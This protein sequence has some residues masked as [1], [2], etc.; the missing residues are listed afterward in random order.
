MKK[1]KRQAFAQARHFLKTQARPLERALFE[2]H[3]E[4]ASPQGVIAELAYFQN[5]DGGFG[6]ALEPDM[7]TPTSSAL[8]TGMG[9]RVLAD[10]ITPQDLAA[11]DTPL[12]FESAVKFLLDTFD[13]QTKVWRVVLPDANAYPHAG[14][15]HDADGSLARTF[16]DFV[17]IPRA[18]L[19]G[20]LHRADLCPHSASL[21]S[22]PWLEDLTEAT[23]V[24][25]RAMEEKA[26]GGGGDT[27]RYALDLVE[28]AGVPQSYKDRLIP[29][30]R[31]IATVVVSRDPAE[32]DSYCAPPLKIAPTPDA[33]VADILAESLQDHLDYQIAH[34]TSE[35]TWEPT[36]TWGEA[37]PEV[38]EQA[39][40]E[41]RGVLT[42]DTLVSLDA[43]GR[44]DRG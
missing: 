7:R 18:Q 27:L 32:W 40:R 5:Q 23:V 34:Q 30:L 33:L 38:W 20:L 25:I 22:S 16:D 14:W 37:Y 36:W 10:V 28:T 9:M 31:D 11:S 13:P 6:N 42:L 39:K 29:R 17:V 3:F 43:F 44:I 4:S 1:L 21:V 2:Y 24:D 15:W 41:W 35:G 26:F 8:A 12:M 19:V